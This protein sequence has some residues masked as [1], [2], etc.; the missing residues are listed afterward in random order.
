MKFNFDK[1]YLYWGLTAFFVICCSLIF[2]YFLFNNMIVLTFLGKIIHV[3]SPIFDGVIIAFLL[4]PIVIWFEKKFFPFFNFKKKKSAVKDDPADKA[5]LSDKELKKIKTKKILIRVFSVVFSY[6]LMFILL[7]GFFYAVI[8][9]IINSA[10]DI[11]DKSEVY[12]KTIE[13]FIN[14]FKFKNPNFYSFL[15]SVFNDYSL[16]LENWRDT[17]LI[18]KLTEFIKDIS[19]GFLSFAGALW[20]IILGTIISL[21]IL[22]NKERFKGQYK[23]MTFGILRID[24]ANK[25]LDN[26]RF[27]LDKFNSFIVGKL[28]D[29]LIIGVICYFACLILKFDYPVL[30]ALI[31]GVTN[32]IPFFGPFIGGG[33]CAILLVLINPL[34]ALYFIIFVVIL[35]QFDGN[36][37]GP[38]LL[39]DSTG[40][41]GFWV[42]FSI[43]LFG[44]LWGVPGMVIGVPTFAV[45]YSAIKIG[46]ENSLSKKKIP[47]DSLEYADVDHID[48]ESNKLIYVDY[49]QRNEQKENK[50]KLNFD[51]KKLFKKKK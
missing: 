22:I 31:V 50:S 30:I 46:V 44:G 49:V 35:Q 38:M 24:T 43:T 27:V 41:S 33:I 20:N 29:S 3:L 26:M 16:Q 42:I 36:L 45:I 1:K 11:Y 15:E 51:F 12:K 25:F 47:T 8:P 13:D 37:L 21:Y 18:P 40:L 9:Q 7:F 19:S 2:C 28:I 6:L 10:T 32:I 23:K 17:F 39:G 34:K 48:L 4:N 5:S 14:N